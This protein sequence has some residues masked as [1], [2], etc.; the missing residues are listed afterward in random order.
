MEK[1]ITIDDGSLFDGKVSKILESFGLRGLFFIPNNCEID[2]GAIK[3]ISKKHDIG[4]HTVSHALLTKLN[5]K[6]RLKEIVEN[7]KYLENLIGRKIKSFAYPRGWFNKDVI[8]SVEKAG[9]ERAY[10]MKL[11]ITNVGNYNKLSLPRTFHIYPR[12][13]YDGSIVKAGTD[14]YEKAKKG[15]YF[16][17]AFH[18]WEIQKFDL[19]EEFEKLLEH[20]R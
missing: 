6:E 12:K 13:E 8:K 18:G 4:G 20:I 10:T 15:G 7:K 19:W 9:Y 5:E 2:E 3:K 14:L 16:N 1:I 11:G 17:M